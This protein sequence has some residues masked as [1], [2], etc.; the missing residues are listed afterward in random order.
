MKQGRDNDRRGLKTSKTAR[1]AGW[2]VGAGA[3]VALAIS[4]VGLAPM[5]A[6]AQQ[7]PTMRGAENPDHHE[8]RSGDTLWDLSGAYFGDNYAW[9]RM[10]SF[11]PHIT[12]PHWIYPGDIIHLR[13]FEGVDG[14]IEQAGH[15]ADARATGDGP[16]PLSDED[17]VGLY[18]ALGGMM[19]T[20]EETPVGRIIGSPV[21][22]RML[23]EHQEVWVGFGEDAYRQ[24]E[25]ESMDEDDIIHVDDVNAEVGDRFALIR[26]AGKLK[27]D[28]GETEAIKYYVLGSLEIT[29]VP[30]REGV[31]LT[32]EIDKSWREIERGDLLVPYERQLQL[33][34][35]RQADNDLVAKV[36]DS[37]DPS[38]I[39]APQEYLFVNRGAAD[40]VRAGNRFFVYQ[41]W[42]GF[43]HPHEESAPEIPWQQVGQMMVIS[44]RESYSMAV[45]TRAEREILIGDRLEMYQGH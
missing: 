30:T 23:A 11:N 33:I 9:P 18:M 20:E 38:R 19:V 35:P 17:A 45:V 44:V 28:D 12:N 37:L 7:A 39:F 6:D 42:E 24:D 26:S 15:H 36:V 40:G 4:A 10:W 5:T 31:A 34:Q 8:V 27:N 22:A 14:D 43:D 1:W 32:G 13:E 29:E 21:A 16:T 3:A 25:R 2:T 41:Q